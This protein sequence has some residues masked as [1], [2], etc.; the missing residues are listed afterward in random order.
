MTA[1]VSRGQASHQGG[2]LP[3]VG[4]VPPLSS[5]QLTDKIN[6]PL[7]SPGTSGGEASKN[8]NIVF[9]KVSG[10]S[11]NHSI[12]AQRKS[13][14]NNNQTSI[15]DPKNLDF[16]EDRNSMQLDQRY[17]SEREHTNR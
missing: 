6:A 8:S 14:A 11:K 5:D 15:D 3:T 13:A 10:L 2:Q 17:E 1:F 4:T 16:A 7:N 9:T 12:K